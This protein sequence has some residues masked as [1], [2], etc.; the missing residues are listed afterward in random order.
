M[1]DFKIYRPQDYN[2]TQETLEKYCYS[3]VNCTACGSWK[4]EVY[5]GS[6]LTKIK[7]LEC[8]RIYTIH[9]S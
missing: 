9:E 1:K 4:F 2:Q 8:D 5:Q 7:C 6:Y 3:K